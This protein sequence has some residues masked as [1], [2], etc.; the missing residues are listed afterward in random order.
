MPVTG[1]NRGVEL[2][3]ADADVVRR[4][5][6]AFVDADELQCTFERQ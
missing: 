5:F 1:T 2:D 3:L 4:H 6:D